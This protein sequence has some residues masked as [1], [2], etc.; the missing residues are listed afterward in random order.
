MSCLSTELITSRLVPQFPSNALSVVS[1]PA[2]VV[3]RPEVG[4]LGNIQPARQTSQPFHI[5]SHR[6]ET[7]N[8]QRST[9]AQR[10]RGATNS[11]RLRQLE[12]RENHAFVLS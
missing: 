11:I 4:F 3:H 12:M 6:S 10:I 9:K 5:S 2:P 8:N 1:A 7:Q